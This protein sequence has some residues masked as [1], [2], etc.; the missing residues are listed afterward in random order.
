MMMDYT[1]TEAAL[2]ELFQNIQTVPGTFP[3]V[4]TCDDFVIGYNRQGQLKIL[5]SPKDEAKTRPAASERKGSTGWL[6]HTSSEEATPA[7]NWFSRWTH[8]GKPV[9]KMVMLTASLGM[10]L[11]SLQ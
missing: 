1:E 6:G 11:I 4:Y 7:S 8:R 9:A 10:L 5:S 2:K 3:P